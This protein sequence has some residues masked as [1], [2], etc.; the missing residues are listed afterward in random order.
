MHTCQCPTQPLHFMLIGCNKPP[1]AAL[2]L[3]TSAFADPPPP[4]HGGKLLMTGSR[5]TK[6]QAVG[7]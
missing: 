5:D 2:P 6:H 1:R 3:C 7:Q 4:P